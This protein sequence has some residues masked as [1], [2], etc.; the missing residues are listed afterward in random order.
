MGQDSGASTHK[1]GRKQD[2]AKNV[3]GESPENPFAKKSKLTRTPPGAPVR[4]SPKGTPSK[5]MESGGGDA[6]VRSLN[7]DS[8]VS[9]IDE[10]EEANEHSFASIVTNMRDIQKSIS[11]D[12][13]MTKSEKES[14]MDSLDRVMI[15]MVEELASRK[16]LQARAEEQEKQLALL[17]QEVARLKCVQESSSEA[18]MA[19]A[20]QAGTSAPSVRRASDLL[21]RLTYAEAT[22]TKAPAEPI[23]KDSVASRNSKASRKPKPKTKRP[24]LDTA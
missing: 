6:D 24:V 10:A 5:E 19:E 3:T 23:R 12:R 16:V 20:N 2:D 9:T 22:A 4:E 11:N 14:I 17:R 1:R 15:K 18:T 21:T 7:S 8:E 13:H